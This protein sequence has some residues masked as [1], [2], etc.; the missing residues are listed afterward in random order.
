MTINV[1]HVQ[2]ESSLDKEPQIVKSVLRAYTRI[3]QNKRHVF[4]V[5]LE[6]FYPRSEQLLL[7]P[8][9]HVYQ[10]A[11]TQQQDQHLKKRAC[12]ARQ[13]SFQVCLLPLAVLHV[14]AAPLGSSLVMV[15]RNVNVVHM[16]PYS[17]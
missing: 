4:H 14:R 16:A 2:S 9:N 15:T 13:V 10:V 1:K 11:I 8:A 6:H 12:S 17:F 5:T 3:W 7:R